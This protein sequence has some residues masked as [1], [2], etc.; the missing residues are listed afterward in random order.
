MD[1]NAMRDR[2]RQAK[3]AWAAFDVDAAKLPPAEASGNW[4]ANWAANW[5]MHPSAN[6]GPQANWAPPKT[7]DK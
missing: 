7:E 6:W 1:E 3:E 5:S 2:L 4:G